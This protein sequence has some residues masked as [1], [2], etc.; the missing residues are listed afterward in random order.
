MDECLGVILEYW[1]SRLN[2][3]SQKLNSFV[4]MLEAGSKLKV[5]P[6]VSG[7]KLGSSSI[8]RGQISVR[9]MI[10]KMKMIQALP[11]VKYLHHPLKSTDQ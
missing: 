4:C 11:P 8:C 10:M 5:P 7:I 9:G 1:S 6:C 3:T 2:Q